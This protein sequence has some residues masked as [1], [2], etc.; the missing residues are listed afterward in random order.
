M[1]KEEKLLKRL[2][3]KPKD[4]TFDEVKTLLARYGY[5]LENSG[6]T[7]G[8]TV[9]FVNDEKQIKFKMHK[10][11]NRKELLTY[12]INDLIDFLEETEIL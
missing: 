9:K 2:L 3:Q 6:I 4:F 11:H 7:S 10:P 12:Q 5:Y 1:S 8:S